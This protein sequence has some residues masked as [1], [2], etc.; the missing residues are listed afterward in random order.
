MSELASEAEQAEFLRDSQVVLDGRELAPFESNGDLNI[1]GAIT[2][3]AGPLEIQSPNIIWRCPKTKRWMSIP[4]EVY[5]LQAR[6]KKHEEKI[7][8]LRGELLSYVAFGMMIIITLGVWIA[9]TNDRILL[10]KSRTPTKGV[11]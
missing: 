1:C 2:T 3:E 8:E 9:R 5:T 10:G 11:H 7:D 6:V 4:N